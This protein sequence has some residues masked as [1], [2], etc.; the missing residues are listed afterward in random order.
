MLRYRR[1]FIIQFLTSFVS[2]VLGAILH[3]TLFMPSNSTFLGIVS[4]IGE[5]PM[6]FI[7]AIIVAAVTF[8]LAFVLVMFFGFTED[9]L[10]NGP[11]SER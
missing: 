3:V 2:G 10:E 9:E 8:V 7:N 11:V 1:L 4:Y 6:N 5:D